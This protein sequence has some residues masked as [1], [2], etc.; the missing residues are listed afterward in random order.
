M[1]L[2]IGSAILA[3]LALL[4]SFY[5]LFLAGKYNVASVTRRQ[6]AQIE[7]QFARPSAKSPTESTHATPEARRTAKVLPLT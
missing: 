6:L 3:I 2:Q 4:A 7:A 1:Y 5:A